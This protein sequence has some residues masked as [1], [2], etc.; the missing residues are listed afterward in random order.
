MPTA[1]SVLLFS[2]SYAAL[3]VITTLTQPNKP[4]LDT[5]LPQ[6][7]FVALRSFRRI[8][9]NSRLLRRAARYMRAAMLIPM[10]ALLFAGNIPMALLV[11]NSGENHFVDRVA[12]VCSVLLSQRLCDEI[13]TPMLQT[14][15]DDMAQAVTAMDRASVR[16]SFLRDLLA[17]TVQKFYPWMSKQH[18]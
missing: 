7:M 15:N 2:S 14:Y 17:N 5:G 9:R 6:P 3:C 12:G 10:R 4:V 11:A 16:S 13:V 8:R 18:R 1:Q